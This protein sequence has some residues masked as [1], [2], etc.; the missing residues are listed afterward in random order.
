MIHDQLATQAWHCMRSYCD[1][2]SANKQAP[3]IHMRWLNVPLLEVIAGRRV[4]FLFCGCG[5]RTAH[6]VAKLR[7]RFSLPGIGRRGAGAEAAGAAPWRSSLTTDGSSRNP[8]IAL[9]F[10]PPPPVSDSTAQRKYQ[11]RWFFNHGFMSWCEMDV[12]A[13]HRSLWGWAFGFQLACF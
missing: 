6:G 5:H 10:R 9:R 1:Q 8:D 3:K 12:A 2:H 4:G 13:I 7:P 11:P